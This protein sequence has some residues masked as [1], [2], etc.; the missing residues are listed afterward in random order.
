MRRGILMAGAALVAAVTATG[1]GAGD[2]DTDRVITGTAP[3]TPYRGPLYVPAQHVD[4]DGPEAARIE[5]G[6]AG[7]ALECTGEIFSG[8]GPGEWSERDGGK[9][10]EEGLETYFDIEQPDVPR[11]GYRVER[12]EK[13]R[14]LFSLDVDGR[15]KVAVVVAKDRANAP[16]WGPEAS[17]ACDPSELP[18]SFVADQPYELWTDAGGNRLPYTRIH[19]YRGQEH[20]DWQDADFIALGDASYGRDPDGVLP[21]GALT[22]AYD[23]AARLPADARDTGYRHGDRAL[24]RSADDPSRVYVRD[25]DGVQAWPRVKDGF[26]CR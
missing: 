5:S 21:D 10:P 7:R 22:A 4:E 2:E 3:A 9:T 12:G 1:C 8:G 13:D 20:C 18:E 25:A 14:V 11:G 19:S 17:A 24:W 6:A 26:G 23:G 15:T 16:G